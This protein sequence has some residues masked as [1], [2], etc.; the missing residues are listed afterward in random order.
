MDFN[1]ID[2]NDPKFMGLLQMGAGILA[3]NN[4]RQ[5]GGAAIGQ[6][7]MAGGQHMSE[8]LAQ[9]QR[10]D[11]LKSEDDR[12]TQEFE[13]QKQKYMDEQAQ[14]KAMNEDISSA[15]TPPSTQPNMGFMD[16]QKP[17]NAGNYQWQ[18]TPGGFDQN[19]LMDA[20]MRHSPKLGLDLYQKQKE[21][22]APKPVFAPNGVMINEKDPSNLNKDFSKQEPIDYNK[23]FLPDGTPNTA[24]QQFKLTDSKSSA[25]SVSVKVD[26]KVGEGLAKEI[27]PMLAA[28]KS[29]AE[30]A[31]QTLDTASRIDTAIASGK[32]IA[33]P[34]SNG[35][36]KL[37]QIGNVL[38]INGADDNEKLSNTRTTIQGL[39][40]FS[41]SGR[42]ALKGQG[43]ISDY[44][45]KLL[46][47]ATSGD[48]EDLTV[49]EIK[50]LMGT[51]KRVAKA[52]QTI[53]QNNM[54][55]MRSKPELAGVADFYDVQPNTPVNQDSSQQAL[56][57]P[58]KPSAL[59]LKK[60]SVYS[61]PKGNLMWNGQS[62]EDM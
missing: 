17:E 55:V 18:N 4:G 31:N 15:Y 39:A 8:L 30:G 11:A 14:R 10:L 61:T 60:G 2:W 51:A 32:L 25:P 47:K 19:K 41:L 58:E 1:Q 42:S 52:Q 35:R 26:N 34:F 56:K 45:G 7:L 49:P 6:G 22:A 50:V 28:S 23:P 62:F 40:Q 13:W 12:R 27:G 54:K 36:V 16:A 20:F 43:Q 59:T 24:F 21:D 37:L 5:P 57:M 38:G 29:A 44:E 48:I 3:A 33:G 9:K 53:H 46:Q